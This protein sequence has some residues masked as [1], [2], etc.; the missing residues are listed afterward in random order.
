MN[1]SSVVTKTKNVNNTM[2]CE[3]VSLPGHQG[4]HIVGNGFHIRLMKVQ[5]EA[6]W[7]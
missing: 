7:P 1:G 4:L 6:G 3:N 5:C 2:M